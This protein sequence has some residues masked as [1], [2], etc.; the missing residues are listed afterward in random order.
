MHERR[1]L[2]I[3]CT[4]SAIRDVGERA[5]PADGSPISSYVLIIYAGMARLDL[6]V[7]A[8]GTLLIANKSPSRTG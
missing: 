1:R 4:A 8:R 5:G 7:V 3:S 2:P 6:T